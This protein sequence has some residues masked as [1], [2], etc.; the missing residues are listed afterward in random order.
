[1]TCATSPG[2]PPS[3]P[4]GSAHAAHADPGADQRTDLLVGHLGIDEH[5][6]QVIEKPA[7][8]AF[9]AGLFGK[10]AAE[11][12]TGAG[13][14]AGQRLVQELGQLVEDLGVGL[15]EGGQQDRVAAV[16]VGSAQGGVLRPPA[17]VGE[18][19]APGAGQRRG[20]QGGIEVGCAEFT[21]EGQFRQLGAEG[22]GGGG[23]RVREC[24]GPRL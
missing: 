20:G 1:L 22:L 23:G 8:V 15:G 14:V 5:R 3:D 2:F 16:L 13:V 10:V 24:R 18:E 17:D 21:E 19:S 4:A 7:P 9:G 11:F 12:V 6:E